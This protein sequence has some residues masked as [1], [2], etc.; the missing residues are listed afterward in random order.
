MDESVF[1]EWNSFMK[2]L[3]DR[4]GLIAYDDHIEAL[5]CLKQT[6]ICG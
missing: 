1:L 5:T 6:T 3:Q 4:F 2:A